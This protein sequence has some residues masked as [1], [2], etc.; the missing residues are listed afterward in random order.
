VWELYLG[1]VVP[2]DRKSKEH[3]L[4]ITKLMWDREPGDARLVGQ[5]IPL[6][7]TGVDRLREVLIVDLDQL[8]VL[9]MVIHV[10]PDAD[11]FLRTNER[12]ELVM[13]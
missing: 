3:P 2:R 9:E 7:F 13:A 6:Q 12:Q 5:D 1:L 11:K 10:V 4:E 8:R